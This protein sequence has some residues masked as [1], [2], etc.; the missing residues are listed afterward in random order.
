MRGRFIGESGILHCITGRDYEITGIDS[1]TGGY[2][3]IDE[4]G[5]FYGIAYVYEYP[6]DFIII[7]ESPY[8]NSLEEQH[9]QVLRFAKEIGFV[10]A[11]FLRNWR[12]SDIYELFTEQ[13]CHSPLGDRFQ[14]VL[15]KY[16]NDTLQDL[17]EKEY[18]AYLKQYIDFFMD[19][20]YLNI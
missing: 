8:R 7:D 3:V 9:K 13:D 19:E 5:Q 12:G 18:S 11:R 6:E 16:V 4:V 14:P 10:G 15:K 2:G 20:Q 17:S 1:L